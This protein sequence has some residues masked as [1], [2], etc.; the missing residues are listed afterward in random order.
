MS[1]AVQE[2]NARPQSLIIK[3]LCPGLTERGKIKIGEKGKMITG[4]TGK[5]F[6][7]PKRLD[8]FKV[9]SLFRDEDGNYR[10]DSEVHGKY[11]TQPRVLPVRLLYDEIDLN[12]QCRY[13]CFV[14]KTLW[15]AGDGET[16]QRIHESGAGRMGVKC[17]CGRQ[18]PTYVGADKCKINGTLSVIIDGIERVGGVWKFRTTS[19]NSVVGILSS[20]ALIKRITGGPIAGLPLHLTINPKTVIT[21]TDNKSMNVWVV[22]IEYRGSVEAL[23]R[24]GYE[25]AKHDAV[26]YAKIEAIETEARRL[27]AA[28]PVLMDDEDPQETVEEFYPEQAQNIPTNGQV[29]DAHPIQSN[30][31]ASLNSEY[32]APVVDAEVMQ[33]PQ[34]DPI[35]TEAPQPNAAQAQEKKIRRRTKKFEV[36]PE[37]YSVA[38]IVSCGAIPEQLLQ[39]RT[40]SRDPQTREFI[41][42]WISEIT[43]YKEL[44]Y[45]TAEEAAKLLN[46]LGTAQAEGNGKKTAEGQTY[47]PP[48]DIPAAEAPPEQSSQEIPKAPPGRVVT[49]PF[50][51]EGTYESFCMTQCQDRAQ[52][53]F[54]PAVDQDIPGGGMI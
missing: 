54:C 7:P 16:A 5:E 17:P 9:T 23:Q 8:Y 28:D 49:C 11:G 45:L 20:L 15:C 33:P 42:Q 30:G 26:H 25:K 3:G 40:L 48:A 21:P 39:L 46:I 51:G 14:G 52:S 10:L 31:P 1:Q 47:E 43:G 36:D 37:V 6:Q 53:G 38:E 44:S 12:F 24:I 34:S 19:Y 35:Q 27:I 50:T 32:R 41:L 2:A 4:K 13:A 18:D 29:I 22:G